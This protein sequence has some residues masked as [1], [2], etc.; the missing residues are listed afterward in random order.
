[1]TDRYYKFRG[2]L[3]LFLVVILLQAFTLL[4]EESLVNQYYT[5]AYQAFQQGN[6]MK[7]RDL[8]LK[9][10][11]I[12]TDVPEAHNL[13]GVVKDSFGDDTTAKSHFETALRLKPNYTEARSNLAL[14]FIN[15]GS[16]D[17]ALR[18]VHDGF[19]EPDVHYL[20]VTALRRKGDFVKALDYAVRIT[21]TFP[22]F[23]PA[24]LYAG[25]ELQST[26]ELQE[27][28]RHFRQAIVLAKNDPEVLAAAKFGLATTA[29]KQG[30][31]AVAVP[32][33]EEVISA[34]KGDV[35]SRLELATIYI[36][37]DQYEV[38]SKVLR[39]AITFDPQKRQAHF[40]LGKTL[41][42]LGKKQEAE[43]HFKVFQDL[44]KEQS[45]FE[46][47]KPSKKQEPR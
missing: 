33:L 40:L 22:D 2:F 19:A 9:L 32:L 42:R 23:P 3:S 4:A 18:L 25:M 39:E 16:L 26:G 7:A 30:D 20:V 38:A 21:Q 43:K 24:H 44:E 27:A 11:E 41:L 17:K 6:A 31:Y 37:T 10:L 14:H 36:E 46:R 13:L 35:D 15:E 34:N 47:E 45:R 29:S 8:L 28:E 1:M 12:R 5:E